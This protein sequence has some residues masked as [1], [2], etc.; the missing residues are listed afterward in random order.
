MSVLGSVCEGYGVRVI[1]E[2]GCRGME[3]TGWG[4]AVYAS[5][6]P[7]G[8]FA[9]ELIACGEG[10]DPQKGDDEGESAGDVPPAED[11]K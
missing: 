1:L 3:R 6:K 11:L 7:A 4:D 8:K 2:V 5:L 9:E 10:D